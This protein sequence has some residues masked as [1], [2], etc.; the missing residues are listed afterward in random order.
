MQKD[1]ID[2][3][4]V[5][6]SVV[7]H[8]LIRALLALVAMED[9][10]LHQ[11]DVKTTFLHGDLD[12]EIYMLQPKGFEVIGKENHV[13]RLEKSLYG[14]KQSLRQW[15]RKFNAFMI[16]HN[17]ACSSYD[18]SVYMRSTNAGPLIYLVLYVDDMLVACKNM[19]EVE[20]LKSQLLKEFDMKDLRDAKKILGMEIVRDRS[21]A[22]LYLNQTRYIEKVLKRF[23]M[24]DAKYIS[25]P[26]GSQFKL[27]K[28][29]CPRAKQE[30]EDMRGIP[31][32]N[33]IGS[34]MYARVCSRPD[35]AQAVSMISRYMGKSGK[36]HLDAVKW[37]RRYMK[38]T[39]DLCL[40]FG[41]DDTVLVIVI[42]IL[43]VTLIVESQLRVWYSLWWYSN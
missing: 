41:I 1:C 22:Y 37:L 15:Y 27:S 29:L 35:I 36:Q 32:T 28:D 10:E 38:C 4:E 2:F 14:L 19:L 17:F 31:Y 18:S 16:A 25:T 43:R 42:L 30:E 7:K 34:I 39:S 40:M 8:F 11:L 3:R 13:C 9:L 33:A 20:E 12:E 23:A 26:L 24:G 6:S 5:F 21:K